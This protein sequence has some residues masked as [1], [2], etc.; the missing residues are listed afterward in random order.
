MPWNTPPSVVSGDYYYVVPTRS[1]RCGPLPP[2]CALAVEIRPGAAGP[3]RRPMRAE[4]R[5]EVRRPWPVGLSGP[6]SALGG[7]RSVRLRARGW[8]LRRSCDRV[9]QFSY[10]LPRSKL[11]PQATSDALALVS[12]VSGCAAGGMRPA[13]LSHI[14]P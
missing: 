13:T 11:P 5:A 9:T 3:P 10:L 7:G 1:F 8:R 2:R 12:G 6:P 4:L 14:K